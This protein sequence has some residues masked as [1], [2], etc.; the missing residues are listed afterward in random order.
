M[1]QAI[2]VG[3]HKQLRRTEILLEVYQYLSHTLID[4]SLSSLSHLYFA[5]R[6]VPDERIY[7]CVELN[8]VFLALCLK[9]FQEHND[10][11]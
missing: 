6:C 1:G 4:I 9:F 8:L 5:S 11:V 2:S 3:S 10:C 7:C